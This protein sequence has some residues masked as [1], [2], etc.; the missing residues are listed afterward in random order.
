LPAIPRREPTQWLAHPVP[1][2]GG[3]YLRAL[4]TPTRLFFLEPKLRQAPL[5]FYEIDLPCF[6]AA[7]L[8]MLYH[9]SCV[10]TE[11]CVPGGYPALA[12][13]ARYHWMG[14][15]CS[16]SSAAIGVAVLAA[17]L[18]HRLVENPWSG[19]WAAGVAAPCIT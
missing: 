18:I 11:R 17:L 8:V 4:R 6:V 16:S 1:T 2:P 12:P 13:I 14:W 3:G 7:F 5:H 10:V 19:R 9:H 15:R